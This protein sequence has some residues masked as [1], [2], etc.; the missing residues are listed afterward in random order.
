MASRWLRK[1]LAWPL[2]EFVCDC[3]TA[4]TAK[5]ARDMTSSIVR[6]R[7][8]ICSLFMALLGYGEFERRFYH[9]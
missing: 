3:A 5:N 1:A 2:G 6:P 8:E 4:R 7:S 9:D